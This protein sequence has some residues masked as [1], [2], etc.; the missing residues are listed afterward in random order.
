MKWEIMAMKM[1]CDS[2]PQRK[3][4]MGSNGNQLSCY[5]GWTKMFKRRSGRTKILQ[6][7]YGVEDENFGYTH[8]WRMQG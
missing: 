3:P 1:P 6:W 2:K 4:P 8:R 7:E 5:L